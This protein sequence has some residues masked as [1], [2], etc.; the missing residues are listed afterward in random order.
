MEKLLLTPEEAG[1]LTS[2]GRTRVYDLLRRG[3]IVSVRIG[4]SRR[5]P[6]QALVAYVERV[7]ETASGYEVARP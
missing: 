2:V 3:A 7:R 6:H 5:I 4:R 1:D